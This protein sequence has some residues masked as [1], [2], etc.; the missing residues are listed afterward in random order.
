M[1]P[2]FLLR[3]LV[4]FGNLRI[5][6]KTG[7][8]FILV[9]GSQKGTQQNGRIQWA[10]GTGGQMLEFDTHFWN[11][12]FLQLAHQGVDVH[13]LIGALVVVCVRPKSIFGFNEGLTCG[14]GKTHGILS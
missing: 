12:E 14:I 1:G 7:V 2:F 3:S 10:I 9:Q 6:K 13:H 5:F 4:I 11:G 8:S